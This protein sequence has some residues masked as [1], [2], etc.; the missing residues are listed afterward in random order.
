MNDR[1]WIG[2][3]VTLAVLVIGIRA[4]AQNAPVIRNT[5]EDGDGGWTAI[6]ANA[7]V[8]VTH[9]AANVKEGKAALQFDYNVAKGEL[10]A[11]MLPTPDGAIVKAKAVRFWIK[12]S[13]TAPI[14]VVMQEKG[15]GRYISAFTAPK[16]T[17]QQV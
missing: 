17:W 12:A 5:F 2:G 10:N 16:D 7:K 3:A 13:H 9:D 4:L 1:R 11:M 6:G 14:A 8:N 15:G